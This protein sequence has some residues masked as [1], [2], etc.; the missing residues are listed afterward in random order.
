ML[1]LFISFIY[2]KKNCSCI[3]IARSISSKDLKFSK[4]E[5]TRS[6]VSIFRIKLTCNLFENKDLYIHI[7]IYSLY[8]TS[9]EKKKSD[10]LIYNSHLN[11]SSFWNNRLFLTVIIK[12]HA[13]RICISFEIIRRLILLLF[14][15]Y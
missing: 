10:V 6:I 12:L 7:N 14:E 8:L 4:I 5:P 2:S 11:K 1:N 3:L 9:R 13:Q 15:D